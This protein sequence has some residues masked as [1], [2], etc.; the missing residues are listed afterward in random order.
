[1][2]NFNIEIF[3]IL[4]IIILFHINSFYLF[5]TSYWCVYFFKKSLNLNL[6]TEANLRPGFVR[7]EKN[8]LILVPLIFFE[9]RDS[10]LS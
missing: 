6:K 8:Y 1:M 2:T 10:L 5:I 9:Y 4:T 3:L 7:E